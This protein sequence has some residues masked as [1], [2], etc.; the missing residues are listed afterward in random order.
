MCTV[1]DYGEVATTF[2]AVMCVRLETIVTDALVAA[3]NVDTSRRRIVANA[4]LAFI[5]ICHMQLTQPPVTSNYSNRF[6]FSLYSQHFT[7]TPVPIHNR[8]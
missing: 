8:F 5:G 4:S 7:L 3:H 2:A 6:Y 1:S